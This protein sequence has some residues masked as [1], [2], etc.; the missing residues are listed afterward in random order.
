[1]AKTLI[2]HAVTSDF[3]V[4]LEMDQASFSH[5]VAYDATE[6]SYFMKRPG[7]ETLILEEDSQ[8]VAFLILEVRHTRRSGTIVTL[9]VRDTHRRKG[10][11]TQ[12]LKRAEGIL[13]D[14][15]A[16]MYDLEV[17]VGNRTAMIF[18]KR[19]GFRTVRTLHNYYSNGNDAY[20]MVKELL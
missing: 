1:M 18:Y 11:G 10:Y 8:I 5:G 20:L 2:R 19:H 4:L 7:A 16:E 15:G 13:S 6:L 17:D 12:L 9:D 3:N 14:Y